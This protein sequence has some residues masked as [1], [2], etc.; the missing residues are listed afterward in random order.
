MSSLLWVHKDPTSKSF[1]NSDAIERASIYSHVQKL[2]LRKRRR[3]AQQCKGKPKQDNQLTIQQNGQRNGHLNVQQKVE[4]N[5]ELSLRMMVQPNGDTIDPFDSICVPMDMEMHSLLQYYVSVM[6]PGG[7]TKTDSRTTRLLL[8]C[9]QMFRSTAM[10][11]I[12]DC[13][14]NEMAMYSLL[15]SVVSHG[16]TFKSIYSNRK[17]DEYMSKAL[18]V[19]R[20]HLNYSPVVDEGLVLSIFHLSCAE[21]YRCNLDAAQ[22]HMKVIERLIN[23]MGGLSKID[24]DFMEILVIGELYLATEQIRPS[25]FQRMYDPGPPPDHL[26]PAMVQTW[27]PEPFPTELGQRLL[28]PSHSDIVTDELALIVCDMIESVGV[29]HHIWSLDLHDPSSLRWIYFRNLSIRHRLLGVQVEDPRSNALRMCLLI[30]IMLTTTLCGAKRTGHRLAPVLREIILEIDDASW[31]SHRDVE[32]WILIIGALASVEAGDETHTWFIDRILEATAGWRCRFGSKEHWLWQFS[33]E[34][35]YL[36]R[37][38]RTSLSR[39]AKELTTVADGPSEPT[40]SATL[41]QQL[42]LA[43]ALNLPCPMPGLY[44]LAYRPGDSKGLDGLAGTTYGY[45]N[46]GEARRGSTDSRRGSSFDQGIFGY[47]GEMRRGSAGSRKSSIDYTGEMKRSSTSSRKGSIDYTAAETK[48]NSASTRQPSSITYPGAMR[49][50]SLDLSVGMG[51]KTVDYASST[52]RTSI[53][54]AA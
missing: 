13:M 40:S 22:V 21:M 33:R 46:A 1:S 19:F 23:E 25:V 47:A 43:N 11:V 49:R 31:E 12:Q 48:R 27:S 44:D 24:P 37:I 7:H 50:S 9:S 2:R 14:S 8:R 34:F 28:C 18:K 30:W 51:W 53:D 17:A 6:H 41:V 52:T 38:Q 20:T 26:T 3:N 16:E 29:M 39:L 45:M 35:F 15:A 42:V 36:D 5:G 10:S 54:Q 4:H 32:V